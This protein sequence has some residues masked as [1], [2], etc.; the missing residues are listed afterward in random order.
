MK[1]ALHRTALAALLAGTTMVCPGQDV[2]A[3]S[4]ALKDSISPLHAGAQV[5]GP[6]DSSAIVRLEIALRGRNFSELQA[7]LA[8][9]ESI[10]HREMAERYLPR[11]AEYAAVERWA[12]FHKLTVRSTDTTNL[13]LEVEGSAA[14]V[15]AAFD[16]KLVQATIEG[17][18][19]IVTRN[20]PHLPASLA[21]MVLAINGLQP[22]NGYQTA[23]SGD[24]VR[25]AQQRKDVTADPGTD[26]QQR[27]DVATDPG[28]DAQQRKDVATDPGTDAQQ[29][30]DVTADPG[31]DAQQRK[32]VTTDPGT[33]AQQRKDVTADPGTDAQQRKDVTTDP[34]TDAQQRKDVT[35]EP[36]TDAQQR[37]DVTNTPPELSR[38]YGVRVRQPQGGLPGSRPLT[39]VQIR[40]AYGA[41]NLAVTGAGQRIAVLI[42]SFP[43]DRDLQRFW[44]QNNIGQSLDNIEKVNTRGGTLP[45]ARGEETLDVE[46]ASAI[47]P[48]AKIRVYATGD[49]SYTSVDRGLRQLIADLKAG[50]PIGQ[51]A[52]SLGTCEASLPPAQVRTTDQL[53][54]IIRGYGVNIFA[55]SGDRGA[56]GG[57][58]ARRGVEFP[59]SSAQ[60]TA[61]GG[62]SL[63]LDA[64]G[65]RVAEVGWPGSGG[66]HSTKFTA[67]GWQPT[68]RGR[69]LPDV[70][71]SA[72]PRTGYTLVFQG[73]TFGAAGTSAATPVW[74]AFA[75]LLNEG[76]TLAGKAPLGFLP[77]LLYS[78]AVQRGGALIDITDGSN[79]A[80]RSTA[81]YDLVTG[82]GVPDLGILYNVLVVETP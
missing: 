54:A 17:R 35:G 74:A 41:A 52:I 8:A 78:P 64:D 32:D 28:T 24:L 57:C 49:L 26:A 22:L 15:E 3:H 67:P 59:A 20:A 4:V 73:K 9:G 55:A 61:V 47:A 36:G 44:A 12:R 45:A 71:L 21:R 23:L 31:T 76:R 62:T 33:D 18:R 72:D 19:V 58:P 81:S 66:G 34:G 11:P 2:L 1:I 80:F 69:A 39:P 6:A 79:G 27:K 60:V 40:T 37:K 48:Q 53:L 5:L 29:R 63:T 16:V 50:L 10:T 51:L 30:K 68:G 25:D 56:Y 7:R 65:K 13:L 75:A 43:D 77:P 70:S 82:L 38:A 46:W 42:D 14:Q